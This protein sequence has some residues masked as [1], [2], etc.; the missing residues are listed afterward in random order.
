M[1]DKTDYIQLHQAT[2]LQIE[3]Q[4][5]LGNRHCGLQKCFYARSCQIIQCRQQ[6]SM[7]QI[8]QFEAPLGRLNE[9]Q[10]TYIQ[11]SNKGSKAVLHIISIFP[12][13]KTGVYSRA[14]YKMLVDKQA[15]WLI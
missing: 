6:S 5:A 12:K 11:W 7:S 14:P 13:K 1:I 4:I 10:S 3:Y 15:E 8:V 9:L 2:L